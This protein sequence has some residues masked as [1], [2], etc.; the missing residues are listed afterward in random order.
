MDSGSKLSVLKSRLLDL[1]EEGCAVDIAYFDPGMNRSKLIEI[2][3]PSAWYNWFFFKINIL[4]SQ[5]VLVYVTMYGTIVGWDLRAYGDA[6]RIKNKSK[7]GMFYMKR[8]F[9]IFTIS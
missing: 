8:D 7:Q 3:S 9:K 6:W 5:A 2:Y 1:Q 4:G